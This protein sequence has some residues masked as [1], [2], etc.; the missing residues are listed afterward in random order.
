MRDLGRR[1]VGAFRPAEGR[2]GQGRKK[3]T[4][5]VQQ[6]SGL[7][8]ASSNRKASSD[9]W[10]CWCAHGIGISV[11]LAP[12]VGMQTRIGID[13]RRSVVEIRLRRAFSCAMSRKASICTPGLRI[14]RLP[15]KRWHP[16]RI[17][18]EPA[19]IVLTQFG[20]KPEAGAR[21]GRQGEAPRPE[22]PSTGYTVSHW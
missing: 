17:T 7:A 5:A 2:E 19:Q 6:A 14:G 12:L 10:N 18:S 1:A 9:I 13:S 20:T 8:P 22:F 4:R 11:H 16:T 15:S 21:A 3:S